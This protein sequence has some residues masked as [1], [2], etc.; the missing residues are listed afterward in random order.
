[1][2]KILLESTQS[3]TYEKHFSIFRSKIHEFL[4]KYSIICGINCNFTELEVEI[5]IKYQLINNIKPVEQTLRVF[6]F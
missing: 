2:I 3:T 5:V 6:F 1:L 4:D